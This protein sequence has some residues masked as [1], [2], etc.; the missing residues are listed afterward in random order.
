MDKGYMFVLDA[1]MEHLEGMTDRQA[2]E[3]WES[4]NIGSPVDY[5]DLEDAGWNSEKEPLTD[6][7]LRDINGV[8][9]HLASE[10]A[11]DPWWML[12]AMGERV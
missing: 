9:E 3:F 10:A 2:A 7:L 6:W 5:I 11:R 12:E 4:Y 1:V 8:R